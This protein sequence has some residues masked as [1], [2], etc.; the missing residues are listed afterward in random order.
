VGSRESRDE[1]D[2]CVK[3]ET[4]NEFW[5]GLESFDEIR[6]AVDHCRARP[7]SLEEKA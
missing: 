3:G 6:Y 7:A 2:G 1:S 5:Y 4:W